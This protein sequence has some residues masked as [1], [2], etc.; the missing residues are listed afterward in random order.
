[1]KRKG[2]TLLELVI[3]T[4]IF[5]IVIAAAYALL[6]SARSVTSR[7]EF[8][9]QLFQTARVALQA[10]E[11]EIRGAVMPLAPPNSAGSSDLAFIGTNEGSDKEPLDRLEFVTVSRHTASAYD[12]NVTE[13]VR[14]IDAAKVY[15]W[16]EQDTSRK[17][18]GLVRERP[19][20]LA[21]LSGPA[22][23][24]EDVAEIAQDVVFVNF[25]YYDSG[26]WRDTWD[27][28]QL[29]KLPKAVEVTVYV[30]GEWRG[31]QVLEPFSSRIYL[32]V[33]GETPERT[34]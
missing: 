6:D 33:G 16:I 5:S 10:V 20:E 29:R 3:A 9:S 2:F 31:E 7:T 17:A 14:G 26:E 15:L 13:V 28:T 22:H 8:R 34:Q 19:V 1:M 4:V 23:R 25:R 30:R 32:P 21:P 12:V 11:D 27:S 18:H 24:L